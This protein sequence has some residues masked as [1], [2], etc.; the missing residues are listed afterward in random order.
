MEQS[1]ITVAMADD[2]AILRKGIIE[3]INGFGQFRVVADAGDGDELLRML[4]KTH[5]L[6]DVCI[7]DINMP[8]MDGYETLLEL[9]QRWP[10]IKVLVLTMFANE[11][12]IIR[13]I[14][15]GAGG[16]LLK[17]CSPNELKQAL[18]AIYDHNY[19]HTDFL[20]GRLVRLFGKHDELLM[21]ITDKEL[22]FLKLCCTDLGYKQIADMLH[23]S[24]RTVE[25]YRNTLFEKLGVKTRTGLAMY[26][27]SMGMIP[28]G[29]E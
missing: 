4:D 25:G 21:R 19:Y 14:R 1:V 2:H 9:K 10:E 29:T 24:P 7:L 5:P 16:Y 3:I 28:F 11:Y 8:H 15:N 22:L 23:V 20:S 12:N 6:P 13:M 17:S 26:A 27:V 18:E